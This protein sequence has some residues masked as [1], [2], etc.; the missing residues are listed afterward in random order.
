MRIRGVTS[1]LKPVFRLSWLVRSMGFVSGWCSVLFFFFVLTQATAATISGTLT[2]ASPSCSIAAGASTCTV[3]LTWSTTNPVG[4]SAVMSSYPVANTT[5]ATGNSGSTTASVPHNGRTFYLYNSAQLLA[6]STA[7]ASCASGTTWNGSLCQS[8]AVNPT[9]TLTLASSSCTI[10]AGNNRC[11]VNATWSTT[12]PGPGSTSAIT[13]DG[14]TLA[15]GNSGGPTPLPVPYGSRTFYL[16]N[17]GALLDQKTATASCASGT[18]WNGSACQAPTTGTGQ[19]TVVPNPCTIA[20][21]GGNCAVILSWTT[22]S[23]QAARVYVVD[24]TGAD[25]QLYT[26]TSGSQS[27]TW[28][29]AL[30]QH[31]TFNLWDYSSGSRGA[32]VAHVD[33]SATT[34]T[35]ASGNLTV[36]PNPCT[37]AVPGGTCAVIV[38]WTTAGAKSVE[39]WESPSSGSPVRLGQD[40]S[41]SVR[42]TG[43]LAAPMNY[44]FQL[45][46]TSSGS[47]GTQLSKV[48]VSVSAP[49]IP[50]PTGTLT[51]NPNPC[52]VQTPGGTCSTTLT[53]S[54]QNAGAVELWMFPATG[55]PILVASQ[56]AGSQTVNG[57]SATPQAYDFKLF[58]KANGVLSDPLVILRM[59]IPA[60]SAIDGVTFVSENP[61]DGATFKIGSTF[62]KSWVLKNTGTTTWD[63]YSANFVGNPAAGNRSVNLSNTGTSAVLVPATRP[64]ESA[65]VSIPMTLPD[66]NGTYYSYWQL[67]NSQGNPFGFQFYTRVAAQADAGTVSIA[68]SE[69]FDASFSNLQVTATM[70]DSVQS[71]ISTGTLGW[72]LSDDS[73][74]GIASGQL[75]FQNGK[76]SASRNFIRGLAPGR[77][78]LKY[79]YSDGSTQ[80]SLTHTVFV[81]SSL[82]VSGTVYDAGSRKPLA[83]IGVKLA[84]QSAVTN[85]VGHY[86]FPDIQLSGAL[87]LTVNAPGYQ[88]FQLTLSVP[89]AASS[90]VQDVTLQS[91]VGTRPTVVNVSSKRADQFTLLQQPINNTYQ[92]AVNWG[93][94]PG[95]VSAYLNGQVVGSAAGTA[96]GAMVDVSVPSGIAFPGQT[97]LQFVAANAARLI[98]TQFTRQINAVSTPE[99]LAPFI[100]SPQVNDDSDERHF[101]FDTR[102]N[103]L[104]EMYDLP[105]M[106][107]FGANFGLGVHFDFGAGG[108][109]KFG[110][111][112]G[113]ANCKPGD[114]NSDCL[115][116]EAG[117]VSIEGKFTASIGNKENPNDPPAKFFQI[118]NLEGALD[119]SGDGDMPPI[120][121]GG[122]L[123]DPVM[124]LLK[125]VGLGK[126]VAAVSIP[127]HLYLEASATGTWYRPFALRFPDDWEG[128]ID[129]GVGSDKTIPL[130]AAD[131]TFK[132]D[133]GLNFKWA[134]PPP[135]FKGVRL[136][137][138]A[139]Y[140]V[141]VKHLWL[142]LPNG[143]TS[144]GSV[145]VI[146]WPFGSNSTNM[147]DRPLNATPLGFSA[148]RVRPPRRA[149]LSRGAPWFQGTP[150][151]KAR[152]I[153]PK[154][155]KSVRT[156]RALENANFATLDSTVVQNVTPHTDQALASRDSEMMLLYVS[157]TGAQATNQFT[158]IYWT[159][160]DGSSWNAPAP[161]SDDPRGQFNPQVQFDGNG[162]AIAVW[163][164]IKTTDIQSGSLSDILSQIEVVWSRWDR[165]SSTWSTPVTLTNDSSLDQTPLLAGP[166]NDGTLLLTWT[167]NPS[168]LL[169][170]NGDLGAPTNDFVFWSQWSPSGQAWST[171][172][173]LVGGISGRTSQSLSAQRDKAVYA[174]TVQTDD[175]MAGSAVYLT[176][177]AGQ[178]WTSTTVMNGS[179]QPAGAV[180]AG[181][182]PTGSLIVTWLRGTDLV[183]DRDSANRPVVVRSNSAGLLDYVMTIGSQGTGAILWQG[184]AQTGANGFYKPFDSVSG[185]W[186]AEKQL[187]SDADG[188]RSFAPAWSGAGTLLAAYNRVKIL[189][190]DDG[191]TQ[192]EVD[193]N[194][195][196]RQLSTDAAMLSGDL[197][198][199]GDQQFPG[200]TVILRATVRNIGDTP[201]RDLPVAFYLGDPA[202]G[203][204]EIGRQTITGWLNGGD[205]TTVSLNWTVSASL[206]A[207]L[208]AVAD[209]D[210]RSAD[211]DMSNNS[212]D[213]VI[214]STQLTVSVASAFVAAD[215]SAH[216]II[217]IGN[218]GAASAP[219]TLSIAA[220]AGGKPLNT[221]SVPVLTTGASAQFSLDLDI[222]AVPVDGGRFTI[223]VDV[224]GQANGGSRNAQSLTTIL[225]T[226]PS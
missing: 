183:F 131:L 179:G 37:I 93:G 30:P 103:L 138:T 8:N 224:T 134:S 127:W 57:L 1:L 113:G 223:S 77:Y 201:L 28:I 96:S 221:I 167:K 189:K 95:Q 24:A 47:L 172:Q 25:E 60:T 198:V 66:T 99:I 128:N 120:S 177:F 132:L 173:I 81:A 218:A 84:G 190:A 58:A 161:I 175:P 200:S 124:S 41:G 212:T 133:G 88:A 115:E 104:R 219:T 43:I 159:H 65:T 164:R 55:S 11:N 170:G 213:T 9:G 176:S 106:G 123:P 17:S 193:I 98:S 18:T 71:S 119:L 32:L 147:I 185:L 82:D 188:E 62:T 152:S 108:D 202:A 217:Q 166:M 142:I 35:S 117:P 61:K 51:A 163:E 184:Q 154:P 4:T 151:A 141:E 114:S 86:D 33:V 148:L 136:K 92:V 139:G 105:M 75:T 45:L 143:Y 144:E 29:Q 48:V 52:T 208:Y 68:A 16:Y 7:T 206:P 72:A 21:Q 15:T 145:D 49:G 137:V 19:I 6:T 211:S 67:A 36:S 102:F 44:T 38:S 220:A 97:G 195:L 178:S 156:P 5:V 150:F 109:W 182:D 135:L 214:G 111:L 129:V 94:S 53:W 27:L 42:V 23:V 165:T 31:Y 225:L 54:T 13:A 22:N 46:D 192:Q 226:R 203:G 169:V 50:T 101:V 187:F 153:Q 216:L 74:S 89:S 126:A 34:S 155:R 83:G 79:S 87:V 180:Q 204:L 91:T 90:V 76:W 121:P 80:A 140:E 125:D 146:N 63:G 40:A 59:A 207:H 26:T 210:R 209:P 130:G 73:G 64:G 215:G 158:S 186:G 118:G 3:S 56:T 168:N 174:W 100:G 162:S 12:N 70:S 20:S 160:Y 69:S 116:F 39:V 85:G 191:T 205:S 78:S 199:A 197:S 149:Y 110:V 107:K 171:P 122:F 14:Q 222:G 10:T 181:Y 194:V 2:P 157:D 112:G 196:S